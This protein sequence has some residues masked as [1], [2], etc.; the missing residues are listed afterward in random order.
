MTINRVSRLLLVIE[1]VSMERVNIDRWNR[2]EHYEYFRTMDYP[3]FS[4]CA[5]IDVSR[6]VAFTKENS[7]SFYHAMIFAVTAAANQIESF[8]YRIRRNEVWLYDRVHPSFTHLDKESGLF[9]YVFAE[10][11]DDLYAFVR[12]AGEKA[13]VQKTMFGEPGEEARDD[14]LYLTCLPWV[15]FTSVSHP[16]A[17]NKDD[18]IPRISWGKYFPDNG[19][20]LMPLSVQ[21]H[22]ALA[23]GYHVG[24]YFIGL[25]QY[26]DNIS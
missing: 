17:L 21:V 3:Q 2:K 12:Q 18:A 13:A 22:H 14:L 23:D 20:T 15:S 16:I 6:F 5:N 11:G 7:L 8:R 4:V 9:K 19:K 1:G 25:Q 26:L 10:A 24:Q